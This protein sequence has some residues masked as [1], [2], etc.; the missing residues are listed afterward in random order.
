MKPMRRALALLPFVSLLL[1]LAGCQEQKAN[2]GGKENPNPVG[3][4]VSLSPN[5]TEVVAFYNFDN[6]K[7]LGRTRADNFPETV[8][9]IPVVADVKPNYEAISQLKPD[10]VIYNP[11]LFS[12]ADITKLKELGLRL[13]EFKSHSLTEYVESV[14]RYASAVGMETRYNDVLIK[15]ED[16]K[17]HNLATRPAKPLRGVVLTGSGN[18]DY[19]IAGLGTFQADVAENAGLE[20]LGPTSNKFERISIESLVAMNP[21]V[22]VTTEEG[23]MTD[24]L[25]KDARLTSVSAIK[26]QYILGIKADILLRAGA[27]VDMLVGRLGETVRKI[28]ATN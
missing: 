19:M 8:A 15:I 18:G 23:N 28:S 1:L 14:Q 26:K 21:E 7:L 9:S 22:I 13:F 5:T 2:V 25:L 4:I 6:L 3:S 20:M 16:M 24:A 10:L 12:D 11:D 17:S 27:R